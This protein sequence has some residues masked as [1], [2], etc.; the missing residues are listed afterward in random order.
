MK[1][2][3]NTVKKISHISDE[4][5]GIFVILVMLMVVANVILRAVFNSPLKGTFEIV[6]LLTAVAIALGL[7]QCALAKGHIAVEFISKYLPQKIQGIVD[8]FNDFIGFV[9]WSIATIFI[10]KHGF[11]MM[12]RGLVTATSEIPVYPFIFLVGIGFLILSLALSIEL[13]EN[14]KGKVFVKDR[15][16]I[17]G[18]RK[19]RPQAQNAFVK[20][21]K[22]IS[23]ESL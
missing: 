14:V 13:I 15:M 8:I 16:K 12:D 23:E 6:S 21:A 1:G 19:S 22:P 2:F 4:I 17:E 18:L 3:S 7:A 10:I 11:S 5:A 9:F 20:I